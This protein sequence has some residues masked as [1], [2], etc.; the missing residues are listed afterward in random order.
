MFRGRCLQIDTSGT[1]QRN[2]R[3]MEVMRK[4]RDKNTLEFS[5]GSVEAT[6]GKDG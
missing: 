6:H 2:P 4:R 3:N 5:V 1:C